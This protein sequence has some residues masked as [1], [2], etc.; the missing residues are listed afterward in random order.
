MT[1]A[2]SARFARCYAVAVHDVMRA[3]GLRDF[4]LPH[5]IAPLRPDAKAAGRA[6]TLRGRVEP[7][8]APHDTY[9][10]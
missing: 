6:F 3:M 9:I 8:I 5:E 7:G 10:G 4:V 1:E 2:L